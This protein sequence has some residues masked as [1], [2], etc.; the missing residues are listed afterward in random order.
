MFRFP[1]RMT[2][3]SRLLLV[4]LATGIIP[5]SLLALITLS[6]A[7]DALSKQAFNK[8]TAVAEIKHATI[9]RYLDGLTDLTLS[10]ADSL[11]VVEALEGFGSAAERYLQESSLDAP[12]IQG[13]R[14]RLKKDYSESFASAYAQRHDGRRPELDGALAELDALAI[15]L[16]SAYILDNPYP[17]GEKD[18]LDRADGAAAYHRLHERFH[19]VFRRYLERFGFYDIF[20][21]EERTGR[22]LYSVFKEVDFATSLR[23]GPYADT[24]LGQA[25]RQADKAAPGQAAIIDFASYFPSYEAP[26]GFVSAP[27]LNA[28]GQRLGAVVFQFPIGELNAIMTERQGL[29]RAAKPI[30][31]AAII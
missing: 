28:Q 16:Q 29:G 18:K 4:L 7:S 5:L 14:D 20:L 30:W 12:R 11:E 23:D 27:V 31:W 1:A 21:V 8:L 24:G 26:A 25:F 10:F 22:V 3:G 15:A 9:E 6:I 2:L 13:M 19:P 17:T